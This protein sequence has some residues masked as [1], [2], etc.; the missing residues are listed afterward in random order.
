MEFVLDSTWMRNLLCTHLES[1]CARNR[2]SWWVC[3]LLFVNRIQSLWMKHS[4]H[5]L[6]GKRKKEKA[7]VVVG[8]TLHS[9]EQ[10]V[11][12]TLKGLRAQKNTHLDTVAAAMRSSF[13]L[14]KLSANKWPPYPI[15]L[16]DSQMFHQ[17]SKS[18]YKVVREWEYSG[19]LCSASAKS[20]EVPCPSRSKM[21]RRISR[22][23]HLEACEHYTWWWWWCLAYEIRTK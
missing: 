3:C 14:L 19:S 13:Q 1:S 18:A 15:S 22:W 7:Q 23:V 16:H 9:N 20:W 2:P 4:L 21:H 8:S 12:Y 11:M 10:P 17:G 6:M 5:R